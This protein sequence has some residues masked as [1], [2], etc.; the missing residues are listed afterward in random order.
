[1]PDD[2]FGETVGKH[3]TLN[4]KA[5]R[6]RAITEQNLSE[7]GIFAS[8]K[9]EDIVV[10]EYGHTFA[11]FKCNKGHK[12]ARR[13]MYNIF[14]EETTLDAT[15]RYLRKNVSAYS[16]KFPSQ[17]N[18]PQHFDVKKYKEVIPEILAKHN[19]APDEFTSEFVRLLKELL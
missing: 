8:R 19:C 3:I 18:L 7:E 10:H 4:T 13:A 11:V 5:L 6:N 17:N 16:I 1:M 9:I 15:I 12:I 14:G 2:Q